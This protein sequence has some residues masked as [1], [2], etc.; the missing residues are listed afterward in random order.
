MRVSD[1]V[2]CETYPCNDLLTDRYTIPPGEVDPANEDIAAA[3]G[4]LRESPRGPE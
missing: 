2:H 4:L 3:L 1:C